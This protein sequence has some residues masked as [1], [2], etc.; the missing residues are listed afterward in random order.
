MT[1]TVDAVV[2]D[3]TVTSVVLDARKQVNHMLFTF[4]YT[5]ISYM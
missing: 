4:S 3:D 5:N 1:P 2:T